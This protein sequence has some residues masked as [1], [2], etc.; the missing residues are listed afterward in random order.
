MDDYEL[1]GIR[2]GA[3]VTEVRR[4]YVIRAK[5]TH[6]DA[7]GR[8]SS[9]DFRVIT[10]AY[11]R[12]SRWR[13]R[14]RERVRPRPFPKP[15]EYPD[16][17]SIRPVSHPTLPFDVATH[18][19]RCILERQHIDALIN[20]DIARTIKVFGRDGKQVERSLLIPRGT[21]HGDHLQYRGFALKPGSRWW[22]DLRICHEDQLSILRHDDV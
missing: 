22:F 21:K 3:S 13:E 8:D 17:K 4:A 5:A 12:L 20:R 18:G 9:V 10:E 7:T 6:P 16:F 1:L 15:L 11:R 19:A 14:A 2:R